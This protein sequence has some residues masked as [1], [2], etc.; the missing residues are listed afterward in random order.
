MAITVTRKGIDAAQL[1]YQ[2]GPCGWKRYGTS[3]E[4]GCEFTFTI[5]DV[6]HEHDQRDNQSWMTIPCP[7]CGRNMSVNTSRPVPATG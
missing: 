4:C 5:G 7:T 3:V 6:K 1:E 2:A